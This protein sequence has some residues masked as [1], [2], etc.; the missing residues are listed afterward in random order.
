MAMEHHQEARAKCRLELDLLGLVRHLHSLEALS[1]LL[2]GTQKL[3]AQEQLT[4]Q[5]LLT[6][7]QLPT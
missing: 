4:H 7:H 3:M 5:D 2:H 6:L 1:S